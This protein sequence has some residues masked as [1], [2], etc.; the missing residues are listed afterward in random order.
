[1]LSALTGMLAVSGL[2][3]AAVATDRSGNV[4][5]A[6][7]P[8]VLALA[9]SVIETFHDSDTDLCGATKVHIDAPVRIFEDQHNVVHLT[10]SDPRARGW[11]WAGAAADFTGSPA[12]ARLDCV[13]IMTGD[14]GNDVVADFDQ[15]TWIQGLYF[16]GATRTVYGYGHEDYFGTRVPVEECHES[17]T[18]DGDPYC[19]YAS[20]PVWTSDVTDYGSHLEFG[21]SGSPPGHVA[22]YPHVQYPGHADTPDAGWIGYGTPSNLFRGRNQDGSLDGYHYMFAYASAAYA[23]QS[24]GVCLFRS[25]D[26]ADRTSWRAWVDD[27]PGYT[28]Q[29]VNPYTGTNDECDVINGDTFDAPVRS[30]LWHEPS[31]HYIAVFR[32]SGGV[33]YATSTDLVSWS[34]SQQLLASTTD[35]AKYPVLIDFD[36]GG[37]GDP[38]FDRLHDDGDAYVVYRKTIESGHTRIVRRAIT[39]SNYAADPPPARNRQIPTEL[40]LDTQDQGYTETGSWANSGSLYGATGQITRYSATA[41]A[42]AT[43]T[44]DIPEAG[45]YAVSVWFPDN[46]D[47]RGAATYTVADASGGTDYPVD[48]VTQAGEWV[49]LGVHQFDAGT[50]GS[51]TLEVGAGTSGTYSRADAVRFREVS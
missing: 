39:V 37:A 49:V 22:I 8:P 27:P 14:T 30:V 47:N 5:V 12:A 38:A 24:N 15:K 34:P 51:V 20:I 33:R 50:S 48:Q 21:K 31:R 17:G 9:D 11:Q 19:W 45:R 41:G 1:M 43:W 42:T 3:M 36:G 40:I 2:T 18:T 26:P 29:M 6:N 25:A 7:T 13:P 44:P 4:A 28:R 46:E 35:E 10:T 32:D 16:D 23:G